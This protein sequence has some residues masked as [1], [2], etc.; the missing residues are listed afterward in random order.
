MKIS[1]HDIRSKTFG[2]K[3]LGGLD[4]VE[5]SAFL[6]SLATAWDRLLE[7]NR[8]LR[9]RLD[10]VEPEAQQFKEYQ[11]TLLSTINNTKTQQQEILERAK[12]DA[13]QVVREATM[14]ADAIKT[15][16]E[17][18]SKTLKEESEHFARNTYKELKVQVS[19]LQTEYSQ[20]QHMREV[21]LKELRNFTNEIAERV[22]R[23]ES[24]PLS[25]LLSIP[26]PTGKLGEVM[27]EQP[28][29]VQQAPAQEVVPEQNE[30]AG[31]QAPQNR[32][33]SRQATTTKQ[34]KVGAAPKPVA[35]PKIEQKPI[36]TPE[37]RIDPETINNQQA[38]VDHQ[39]TVEVLT[40]SSVEQDEVSVFVQQKSG[41]P[42]TEQ[43]L[44][45]TEEA[46]NEAQ[47]LNELVAPAIEEPKT[48][49]VFALDTEEYTQ[50]EQSVPTH[51]LFEE[52]REEGAKKAEAS[53]GSFFDSFD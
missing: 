19:T 14:K 10:V 41:E 1:S 44:F 22:E 46:L 34:A 36:A 48:S 32:P 45:N 37:Q 39:A 29:S 3:F 52:E 12:S 21:L 23:V 27:A 13:E 20:I 4:P 8:E 11:M 25:N 6:G 16:A 42:A 51:Q 35:S 38:V 50:A 15:N 43:E 26:Q 28:E 5:V 31:K 24:R 18:T 30:Q 40:E 9:Q 7:E 17:W 53:S 49:S 2:T 33:Y 47:A